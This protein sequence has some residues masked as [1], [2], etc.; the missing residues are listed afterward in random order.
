MY[1]HPIDSLG[2]ILV[3]PSSF[4]MVNDKRSRYGLTKIKD[5]VIRSLGL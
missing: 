4:F 5:M 3:C 1:G 2:C